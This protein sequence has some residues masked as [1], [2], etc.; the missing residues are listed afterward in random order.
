MFQNAL[1]LRLSLLEEVKIDEFWRSRVEDSY[2]L[3]HVIQKAVELVSKRNY[4]LSS[5]A[6]SSSN[7]LKNKSEFR[8]ESDSNIL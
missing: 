2:N 5:K 3:K 1:N 7:V 8:L 4:C 6:G